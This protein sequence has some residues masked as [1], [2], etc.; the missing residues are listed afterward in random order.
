MKTIK[1]M[2]QAELAAFV[3]SHLRKNDIE[4][5]LTGGAA[6]SVYTENKY[7]SMDIDLVSTMS[8]GIKKIKAA[9]ADLGFVQTGR[10]FAHPETEFIVEFPVGPPAV[11]KETVNQFEEIQLSTGLLRI[12]S[13]TDCVRDRLAH[14]YHWGDRQALEQAV[15]VAQSNR[16]DLDEIERWSTVENKVVEFL[17]IKSRLV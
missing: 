16:V 10:H 1:K 4:V 17:N 8:V 9:L 5:V 11:G 6:V 7:V 3:Q 2:T 15:M 13:P 14:Y 12:L